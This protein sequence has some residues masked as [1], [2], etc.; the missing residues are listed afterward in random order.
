MFEFYKDNISEDYK[1]FCKAV[2][3]E[4]CVFEKH[5]LNGLVAHK[6][7]TRLNIN[8]VTELLR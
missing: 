3:I 5:N 7:L 2:L 6:Y 4:K 8:S 1:N